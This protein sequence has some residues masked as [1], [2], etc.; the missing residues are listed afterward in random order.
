MCKIFLGTETMQ[1]M[2]KK[3]NAKIGIK[4]DNTVHLITA[5]L[6]VVLGNSL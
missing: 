5:D 1:S 6:F 3:R 4:L 2:Q